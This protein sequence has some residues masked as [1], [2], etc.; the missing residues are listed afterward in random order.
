MGIGK[1]VFKTAKFMFKSPLREGSKL[2]EQ[3]PF[4]ASLGY[5]GYSLYDTVDKINKND[6]QA[7]NDSLLN[8]YAGLAAT[9]GSM[10][11][12]GGAIIF[13]VGIKMLGESTK[14]NFA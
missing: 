2:Y 13:G 1:I 12:A 14:H 3:I 11:G 9:C 4:G 6:N 8:A 5:T 7:V 10:L